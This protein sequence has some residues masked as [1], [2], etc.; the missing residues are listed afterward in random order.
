MLDWTGERFLPWSQEAVVAYEHLHRYMWAAS[1]VK[2]KRVL[3]LASG[4]GYG[5]NMLACQAEY[6]CGVDIDERAVEHS[7]SRYKRPNL[8]F[9]K[10]S[11][12]AVPIADAN[13]FDVIVCFEAIEHIDAHEALV[14]EVLR[15]LR[16]GG[17]FIVSTP[18]KSVYRANGEEPNPFHVRELT[19]EELNAL[20]SPHFPSVRYFGQ[21]VHPGSSLWPLGVSPGAE[22]KEFSIARIQEEF[23]IL[24]DTQRVATYFIAVASRAPLE[25][26]YP[27][28][29]LW[30]YSDDWIKQK[31]QELEAFRAQVYQ[32]DEA[33]EWRRTQ[34]EALE[35]EN[36]EHAARVNTLQEQL[37]Q[38]RQ[39]LE[40]IHQSRAWK[41]VLKLRALRNRLF[42]IRRS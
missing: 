11:V 29:V 32:R 27:G 24:Q 16:P 7:R 8:E 15:L 1:L 30:D 5:S 6:V 37:G 36:Q 41:L 14:A 10:G 34:V 17:L 20:L 42:P 22:M 13:S 18:N 40:E 23:Q 4:E 26:M 35:R 31:N 2:D 3:D 38:A 33:L 25:P 21:S 9:L 19:F 12:T 39:E 28:S